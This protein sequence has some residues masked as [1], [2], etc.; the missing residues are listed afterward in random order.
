MFN[1]DREG[2]WSSITIPSI[3]KRV[4]GMLPSFIPLMI[5]E[6]RKSGCVP[7]IFSS[8]SLSISVKES[9][10]G[11]RQ[12]PTACSSERKECNCAS[13]M[14]FPSPQCMLGSGLINGKDSLEAFKLQ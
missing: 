7:P 11:P 4:N 1:L 8:S 14:V 9:I 10:P 2:A 5:L 12:D 3:S 6:A 13:A